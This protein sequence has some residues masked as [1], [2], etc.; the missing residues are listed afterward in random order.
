M[1]EAQPFS[2]TGVETESKPPRKLQHES[3]IS[4]FFPFLARRIR[5]EQRERWA[6]GQMTTM[7]Y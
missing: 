1:E 5:A 6:R 7:G 2:E 4:R 3:I